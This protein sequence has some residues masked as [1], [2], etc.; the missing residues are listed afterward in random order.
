MPDDVL[1]RLER[2]GLLDAY[3]GRPFYQRN[4]YPAWIGRARRVETREKRIRQML[5]ELDVGGIYMGMD[6]P[7]SRRPGA[8]PDT[9]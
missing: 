4:D 5:D 2:E 9:S 3:R 8:A 6:H 1:E 7:P